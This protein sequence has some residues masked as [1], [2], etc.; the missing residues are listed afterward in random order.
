MGLG[1]GLSVS[2][3]TGGIRVLKRLSALSAFRVLLPFDDGVRLAAGPA[4]EAFRGLPRSRNLHASRGFSI[5]MN[6]SRY[7][8]FTCYA[9]N[10][11]GIFL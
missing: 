1:F 5:A 11:H 4:P 3:Q 2:A 6:P 7:R 10:L 9:Q 8:V